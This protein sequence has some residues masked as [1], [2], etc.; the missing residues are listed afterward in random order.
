M[1]L[2]Q[3]Q[4]QLYQKYHKA[5]VDVLTV[6]WKDGEIESILV[7]Y[8]EERFKSKKVYYHADPEHDFSFN[9][10]GGNVFEEVKEDE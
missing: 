5:V 2:N 6:N 10:D 7:R 1:I 8:P 4:P 9:Y 3:K